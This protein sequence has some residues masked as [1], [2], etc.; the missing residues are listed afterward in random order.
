MAEAGCSVHE[1]AAVT[2][3]TTLS[4][5]QRHTKAAEQGRLAEAAIARIGKVPAEP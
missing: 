3:H 1:I 2:G 5:V 4:E